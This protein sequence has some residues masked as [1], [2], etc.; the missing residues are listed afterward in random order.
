MTPILAAG[1]LL[2]F[3]IL[4]R[5]Y[6]EAEAWAYIPRKRQDHD[7]RT[8]AAWSAVKGAIAAFALLAGL[9]LVTLSVLEFR[10]PA[11][12]IAYIVGSAIG[13]I[14]LMSGELIWAAFAPARFRRGGSRASQLVVLAVTVAAAVV[15]VYAFHSTYGS[16][17]WRPAEM[18]SGAAVIIAVQLLWWAGS[19]WAAQRQAQG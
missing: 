17:M 10:P 15:G 5:R 9:V 4:A 7:R 14:V 19:A 6:F 2:V 18:L 3:A 12:V 1:T 8:P 11:P 13:V 16:N